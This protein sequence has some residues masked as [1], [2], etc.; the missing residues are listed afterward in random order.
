MR[1]LS[2]NRVFIVWSAWFHLK[3]EAFNYHVLPLEEGTLNPKLAKNIIGKYKRANRVWEGQNFKNSGL[4]FCYLQR[5]WPEG[6][7]RKVCRLGGNKKDSPIGKSNIRWRVVCLESLGGGKTE[8]IF[9]YRAGKE[10]GR[11]LKASHNPCG[12]VGALLLIG[13]HT[14][15]FHSKLK[16][17]WLFLHSECQALESL[18]SKEVKYSRRKL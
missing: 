14:Q 9:H 11:Y 13:L 16:S 8:A 15:I 12:K 18:K 1:I 3:W 10:T 6:E 7:G 2:Q 17:I 5:G 4:H